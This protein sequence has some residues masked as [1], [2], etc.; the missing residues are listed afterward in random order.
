MFGDD[1]VDANVAANEKEDM[2]MRNRQ[3]GG[4]KNINKKKMEKSRLY[5]EKQAERLLQQAM[6]QAQGQLKPRRTLAETP[7]DE[8]PNCKFYMDGKCVKV[9][10]E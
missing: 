3:R 7:M 10:N 4:Q 2:F 1:Y 5:K 9:N 8:R 6:E